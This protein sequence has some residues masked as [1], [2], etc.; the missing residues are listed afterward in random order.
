M[1]KKSLRDAAKKDA[2]A[3]RG[4]DGPPLAESRHEQAADAGAKVRAKKNLPREWRLVRRSDFEA[5]YREGR[6][7]SSATFLVFLRANGL[8]RDRFGMSV[9]KALGNAVVRNRMRRR[10]RE[11]LRLHRE[12]ILPGWDVVIHPSRSVETLEFS[13]LETELL[14]LLPREKR[15]AK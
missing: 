6:R 1:E 10:I 2:T 9:K 15:A 8:E 4:S 3:S 14:A 7:R 5:V 11:I 12:E 13:K